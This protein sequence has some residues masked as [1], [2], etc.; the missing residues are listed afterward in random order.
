MG[1]N[2]PNAKTAPASPSAEKALE[3]TSAF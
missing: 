1:Q 2:P 3:G